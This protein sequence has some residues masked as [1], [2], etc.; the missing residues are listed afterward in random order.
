MDS[1]SDCLKSGEDFTSPGEPAKVVLAN[2]RTSART[3][4]KKLIALIVVSPSV[5][6]VIK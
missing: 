1:F 4:I 3:K 6:E 5:K 2:S